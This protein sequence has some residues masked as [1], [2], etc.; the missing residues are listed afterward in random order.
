MRELLD[1]EL[2][3]LRCT[4][5][6]TVPSINFKLKDLSEIIRSFCLHFLI[7][8]TKS[9]LDQLKE[10]LATLNLLS[11][12]Q[13]HPLE[14]RSL[15]TVSSQSRITADEL[16]TLF[17]VK[18]WELEEAVIFN[19][20]NYIQEI[21]G[22]KLALCFLSLATLYYFFTGNQEVLGEEASVSLRQILSFV[23]GADEIP[24]LGFTNSPFILFS[25]D[26]SRLL[27][28]S[29]TC[30]LSITFSL[31]LTEYNVFKRILEC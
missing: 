25:K 13:S 23:T 5:G 29:S 14:F 3:D 22:I 18:E 20:E 17:K 30:V 16:I 2:F 11:K 28:V 6:V 27:P 15:F 7:H 24:P 31:G 1:G 19:W 10:G 26:K 4:C 21:A 8:S 9:E 12:M